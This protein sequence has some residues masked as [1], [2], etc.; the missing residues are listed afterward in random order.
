MGSTG[1]TTATIVGYVGAVTVTLAGGQVL[2]VDV[3]SSSGELLMQ[4][5][6]PGP[7]ASFNISVPCDSSLCGFVMNTQAIHFGGV[8]PFALSNAQDLTVGGL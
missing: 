7:T 1:H 5:A 2:L 4:P 6:L 3:T 8:M